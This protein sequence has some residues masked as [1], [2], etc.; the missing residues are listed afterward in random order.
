MIRRIS[1]PFSYSSAVAAGDYVFIGL[2]RGF[3]ETFEEQ[4]RDTFVHLKNTL[5]QCDTSLDQIVQ[6]SVHLKHIDDLPA[7][8]QIFCDY[9]AQDQYP[10]RMTDTTEFFDKDCLLMIEGI[11][12][13]P[14]QT[15]S[16]HT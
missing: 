6:V 4:I 5:E 7:M 2:H 8:E 15:S 11:A 12:Y 10:A 9:F 16:R 3:G 13:N 1:T 14:E